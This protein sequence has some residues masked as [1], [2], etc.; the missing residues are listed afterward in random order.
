M[1]FGEFKKQNSL[2]PF[3]RD[4]V[5]QKIIQSVAFLYIVEQRL[6]G[7]PCSCEARSAVH[8]IG[9]DTNHLT[10]AGLLFFRHTFTLNYF[11]SAAPPDRHR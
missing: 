7:N 4:E 5:K 6:N 3:D 11:G 1:L 2:F 10:K 8:N 9:I